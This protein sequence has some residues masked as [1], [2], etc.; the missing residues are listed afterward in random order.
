[1]RS[2]HRS[3]PVLFLLATMWSCG[4]A[5][6]ERPIGVGLTAPCS[7]PL[8]NVDGRCWERI[9]TGGSCD[10]AQPVAVREFGVCLPSCTTDSVCSDV[11]PEARCVE[12][13][14]AGKACVVP[15]CD[16]GKQNRGEAG[17]DCGGVCKPCGSCGDGVVQEALGETCD[18]DGSPQTQCAYGERSCEVCTAQC[19]KAPG[20]V[21]GFCGDG[22]PQ[23]ANGEQCDEA[24]KTDCEYND[25]NCKV[26]N[27]QCKEVPGRDVG[28]CGDGVVQMSFGE[29][30][31]HN[32]NPQTQCPQGQQSCM[33]CNTQCKLV[34]GTSTGFCGDG[35]V[36]AASG[37]D[38]DEAVKTDCDYGQPSCMVCND[39]CKRVP[40]QVVGA[41]GDGVVQASFGE[42]CD[43]NG[44]P[45]ADCAYGQMS[46]MVCN[47]QCQTAPGRVT[48]F[49]GDSVVNGS[50]ANAEQCDGSMSLGGL[51]C[52]GIAN[53]PYGAVACDACQLSSVGCFRVDHV[54][55]GE[56]HTCALLSD[57]TV[58]CWG[59]DLYNQTGVQAA[60]SS[61][62]RP[63]PAVTGLS[64]VSK[65]AVGYNHS[66]ALL[67]D[68]SARCWGRNTQGQL[69]DSASVVTTSRQPLKVTGL[70]NITQLAAGGEHTCALLSDGTVRCW[71]LNADGQLGDGTTV[72]RR[73]P[74]VVSGLSG[75]VQIAAGLLSTCAVRTSGTVHCWG[76]NSTYQ[77]GD[78]TV[79]NRSAP[80]QVPGITSAREVVI[81]L[82]S[83]CARLADQS[84]RC[85][86]DNREGNLGY[87]QTTNNSDIPVQVTG[88]NNATQLTLLF[89]HTCALLADGTARCW[90]FNGKGQ[91]GNN[92]VMSS[93]TPAFI[94]NITDI[95]QLSGGADHSCAVLNNGTIKCWGDN[96]YGQLGDATTTQRNTPA[97]VM[98]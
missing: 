13:E 20:Q 2:K 37:E 74:V 77:L 6:E 45:Q 79:I 81:G 33:V 85:W 83:A 67:S 88:I 71:G 44:S 86:G 89:A 26:C 32:G 23:T 3:T 62:T 78:G 46:C 22:T 55:S 42:T 36:Q 24:P 64:G 7:A 75:V 57:K 93:N 27:I 11:A 52:A 53:M 61:N 58:R 38:C 35:T 54:G 65:L 63:L 10:P 82:V 68:G 17:I 95:K 49:C 16:D 73:S 47:A 96:T 31:D 4:D 56:L 40:G 34:M 19:V 66:C 1:M 80:V 18:H 69:G 29:T 41:C 21:T 48:G 28:S 90:G 98:F 72:D 84:V 87:G 59:R 15:Q 25:P 14:G 51:S 43:H 91:L 60:A 9:P 39:Q 12:F 50:G 76:R 97:N 92:T 30:C 5:G 8:V 70:T 94:Q